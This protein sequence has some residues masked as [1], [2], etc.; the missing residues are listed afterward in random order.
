MEIP[1]PST[2]TDVLIRSDVGKLTLFEAPSAGITFCMIAVMVN[3]CNY[4][5]AP[6]FGNLVE[7]KI[8]GRDNCHGAMRVD[9]K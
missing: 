8:G 6:T 9:Q 3:D 1:L 7:L 5:V 2:R 4:F